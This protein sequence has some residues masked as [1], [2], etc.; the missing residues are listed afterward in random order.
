MANTSFPTALPTDAPTEDWFFDFSTTSEVE[1]RPPLP[2]VTFYIY[3]DSCTVTDAHFVIIVLAIAIYGLIFSAACCLKGCRTFHRYNRQ[4]P[5]YRDKNCCR[6]LG[7]FVVD[8]FHKRNLY[9]FILL[10]IWN[11]ATDLGVMLEIL[12]LSMTDCTLGTLLLYRMFMLCLSAMVFYRIMSA[13]SSIYATQRVW[14]FFS[15]L[16]DLLLID[17]LSLDYVFER[18]SLSTVQQKLIYMACAVQS[19]PILLIATSTM[20]L[21]Q[22]FTEHPVMVASALLAFALSTLIFVVND[23]ILYNPNAQQF[24]R[25][26]ELFL[27]QVSCEGKEVATGYCCYCER[28]RLEFVYRALFRSFDFQLRVFL[29]GY[30][31]VAIGGLYMFGVVFLE[32]V[33]L[34]FRA[35]AIGRLQIVSGLLGSVINYTSVGAIK[36]TA[37]F[38][39]YRFA[40]NPLYLGAIWVCVHIEFEIPGAEPF[41][42]RK[43]DIA[44]QANAMYLFYYMCFLAVATPWLYFGAIKGGNLVRDDENAATNPNDP[45]SIIANQDFD[46]FLELIAFQN[47]FH[48]GNEWVFQGLMDELKKDVALKSPKELRL[49]LQSY[50]WEFTHISYYTKAML[51]DAIMRHHDVALSRLLFEK[52]AL[53]GDVKGIEAGIM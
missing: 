23:R 22:G 2:T 24:K 45:H 42:R 50:D 48:H 32:F 3:I 33:V 41:E 39:L 29:L 27:L 40:S 38:N 5:E 11:Q 30:V 37:R 9:L 52:L 51:F 10:H 46:T 53:C 19:F 35:R 14:H 21:T 17:T 44:N 47:K 43:A 1:T 18:T 49:L 15:Q 12:F 16:V 13:V 8:M 4:F 34:Y 7:Q 6:K 31:W 26:D 25:S 36:L 28:F 20:A